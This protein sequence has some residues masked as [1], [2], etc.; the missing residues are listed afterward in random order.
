MKH[1][2]KL[3]ITLFI[4]SV[5]VNNVEAQTKT[6]IK[7]KSETP[8]FVEHSFGT[9]SSITDVTD[10]PD[11]SLAYNS[12]QTLVGKN[13]TLTYDDNTFRGNEPIRRGDF[14]VALNSSLDAIKKV[15]NENNIDSE[16][17]TNSASM[18][19]NTVTENSGIE[20]NAPIKNDLN[21]IQENSV[22]HPAAQS[23][24]QK[25]VILPFAKSKTFNPGDPMSENEVYDILNQV[26]DY[27]KAGMNPYGKTM[28][29]SKFAM[30]LNNAVSNK[31]QK[32]YA[33][34]D[35]KNAAADQQRQE[36]KTRLENEMQQQEQARKDS[37]NSAY[38][39]EQQEI[40]QKA[41]EAQS[42]KKHRK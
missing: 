22:Y 13:I 5:L 32:D 16:A 23:L 29:R 20:V 10:I 12:L 36:E 42:K 41:L 4:F 35:Q 7:T 38:K 31:L 6:K 3:L 37:L 25:G 27:S 19:N 14:L 11:S 15:E 18:N 34:I 39:A 1:Y 8:K 28:D 33:I 30:V 24:T 9:P 2:L 21:D 40:E 17:N 26:F